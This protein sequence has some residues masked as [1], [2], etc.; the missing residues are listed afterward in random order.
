MSARTTVLPIAPLIEITRPLTPAD[1]A[2]RCGVSERAVFRWRSGQTTTITTPDADR[3]AIR[4][5]MHPSAIW[6]EA[7]W[8]IPS[9]AERKVAYRAAAR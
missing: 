3:I 9:P 5:G 8:Q 4:L 2:S 7:W 6:G 1:A